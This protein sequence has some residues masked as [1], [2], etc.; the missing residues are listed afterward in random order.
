MNII[1]NN[2]YRILGVYANSRRQEILANK[3]KATAFLRVGKPIDYP[4]DLN[5]VLPSISRSVEMLNEAESHLSIAK[6]QIKYTQFWFLKVTPLDE[7][8]LRYLGIGRIDSAIMIWSKPNNVSG[9]QNKMVCLMIKGD[10]SSAVLIAE[11]L[12]TQF[13]DKY[14]K[15][16]DPSSNLQMSGTDLL[17]LFLDTL[18]EEIGFS[19]LLD[20]V[21]SEESKSYVSSK[22]I[23]PLISKISSEVEKTKKVDRKSPQARI[24]AAR[25][26][27][28]N[29]RE[30]FG[31]LKCILVDTDSQLHMIADKLGLEI[32]Q[33]G[34]DYFVG[35]KNID[36]DAPYTA[37]K[38]LKY[39]KTIVVGKIAKDRCD[40]QIGELQKYIDNLPPK[41][42]LKEDR[43]I[44]SELDN[45]VKL[46]MNISNAVR[47]MNN[48]KIYLQEIK[49]KL[50]QTNEYYLRMSTQ[51]VSIAM[52]FIVEEVNAVQKSDTIE[53][54]GIPLEI[55]SLMTPELRLQKLN[56]IKSTV[57]EAWKAITLMDDFDLE[58]EF[59]SHYNQNRSTLKSI[60]SDLGIST[61]RGESSES[62]RFNSVASSRPRVQ[63]STVYER[64]YGNASAGESLWEHIKSPKSSRWEAATIMT[65]LGGLIGFLIYYNNPYLY[66]VDEKFKCIAWGAGIGAISWLCIFVDD[67]NKSGDWGDLAARGGCYGVVLLLGLF[68]FYWVYKIIRLSIDGIKGA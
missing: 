5:G 27:V 36:E 59:K 15:K 38:M 23:G 9:L 65:F 58:L 17:H 28:K 30:P 1:N 56:K 12:Y 29:T 11:Q 16:V 13:G 24:E 52:H 14:I 8:A 26:L 31:Q 51:I 37:M 66:D 35:K 22:T 48:T 10:I 49:I 34:I 43:A 3:G 18:G 41:E 57:R 55:D 45:I 64:K 62:V 33:C 21:S 4:L 6:E 2:P 61:Y 50:G 63:Q 67:D 20:Y 19:T 53:I 7:A 39:A 40:D 68:L 32:L 25:N 60:C 44:K 42:V 47:L 46:S 54:Q